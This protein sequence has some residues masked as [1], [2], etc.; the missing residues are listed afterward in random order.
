MNH[1]SFSDSPASGFVRYP[2]TPVPK[3]RM[4]RRDHWKKRPCV[5]RYFGFKDKV[6]SFGITL[7]GG[8][9]HV[10]FR[11]PMPKSWCMKKRRA[12]DGEPH[13]LRPDADNLC[14]AL[15]DAI[16]EDDACIWDIRVTKL[17]SEAG[18]IDIGGS[19]ED[20]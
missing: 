8:G 4:T 10:I 5:V 18:A 19:T 20:S 3:P 7:P 12:M 9:C 11:L 17:W 14:K 2:I 13:L 6:R 16:F 15:L 1:L